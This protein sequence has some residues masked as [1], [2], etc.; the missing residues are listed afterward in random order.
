[1]SSIFPESVNAAG[2]GSLMNLN[3]GYMHVA[4]IGGIGNNMGWGISYGKMFDPR[5]GLAYQLNDKTVLRAGYGRSFDTGVFGSIFG[6]VVTQNL[7]VLANQSLNSSG[8]TGALPFTLAQGP[9]AFVFPTVPNNGLLPA[10]AYQVSP[11]A[12]PDPLHF[13]TID[14]WNLSLQRA[15]TPTLNLTMAYVG[16][17]GTHTLGDT[18]QNNTDPNE[19]A[20]FLPGQ[21]SRNGQTLH[22]DPSAPGISATSD[23]IAADGGVSNARLLK[24]Y[25]AHGLP[26]CRIRITSRSQLCRRRTAIPTCSRPVR[27]DQQHQLLW[28]RS[29]HRVRR[30]SGNTGQDHVQG[31]CDHDQLPVGQRL[32]RRQ[33]LLDLE[34]TTSP[35]TATATCAPSNWWCTAATSCL[36]AKVSSLVRV[37]AARSIT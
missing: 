6:H 19:S 31:S 25:Y 35:T 2:N 28:R 9:P 36:S 26:A 22:W 17:K 32:R 13:P 3:D 23:G 15:I 1:M 27:L 34:I 12:R 16:N 4:G 5:I 10:Q 33:R 37:L 30:G 24:R 18:D 20:L 29:E 7:P 14:A 8:T 11:K 21:Y